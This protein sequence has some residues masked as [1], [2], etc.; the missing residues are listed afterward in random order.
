MFETGANLVGH[1]LPDVPLRQWALGS[2]LELHAALAAN[3]DLLAAVNLI[4]VDVVHKWMQRKATIDG[5]ECGQAGSVT[6]VQRFGAKLNLHPDF[7]TLVLDGLHRAGPDDDVE[8]H[9]IGAPT[10]ADEHAVSAAVCRRVERFLGSSA[11]IGGPSRSAPGSPGETSMAGVYDLDLITCPNCGRDGLRPIAAVDD[12]AVIE[13]SGPTSVPPAPN[14]SCHH[15]DG[16]R[17]GTRSCGPHDPTRPPFRSCRASRAAA[18]HRSAPRRP[19]TLHG[20]PVHAPLKPRLFSLSG[21]NPTVLGRLVLLSGR[22]VTGHRFLVN[23]AR[24]GGFEGPLAPDWPRAVVRASS[25]FMERA[26]SAARA[27]SSGSTVRYS[28]ASTLFGR[29]SSA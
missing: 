26:T 23:L 10:R 9:L 15:R 16:R 4:F 11:G 5:F 27:S 25:S 7:H 2:Q 3:G 21:T 20:C 22:Q 1:V 29:P 14:P 12:P 18:H 6:L 19:T 8:L 28:A 17:G 13:R 24:L